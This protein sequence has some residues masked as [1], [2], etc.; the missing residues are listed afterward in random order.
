MG[1]H[2]VEHNW[3][4]VAVAVGVLVVGRQSWEEAGQGILIVFLQIGQFFD[5]WA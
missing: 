4:N 2:R 1:L 5:T 3:S